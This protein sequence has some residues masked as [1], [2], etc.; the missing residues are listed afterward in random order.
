MSQVSQDAPSHMARIRRLVSPTHTYCRMCQE[1][2]DFGT[3]VKVPRFRRQRQD[4]QLAAVISTAAS[5]RIPK[6]Q[7]VGQSDASFSRCACAAV[8]A[9]MIDRCELAGPATARGR[10]NRY[11]EPDVSN[12]RRCV[13]S[14]H[15]ANYSFERRADLPPHF[16]N[17][18]ELA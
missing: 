10:C 18:L 17:A 14:P 5:C 3:P 6:L 11:L 7:E 1:S 2:T 8:S 15:P 9:I 16:G 13:M 12:C 4:F